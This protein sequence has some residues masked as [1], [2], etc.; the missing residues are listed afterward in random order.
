MAFVKFRYGK[1]NVI[2][3]SDAC[4]IGAQ[5]AGVKVIASYPI[6]PQTIVVERLAQFVNNGELD[7]R[8]IKVESEHSA[9]SAAF[10][11][12]A[13]GVRAFS[14]TNSQGLALMSEILYIMSGARLPAVFGIV[15]RAMSS[16]I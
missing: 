9:C 4:A 5:L 1:K 11:A 7:A 8:M 15:N 10:G 13:A 6:T 14:A 3:G 16:P 12:Q 2:S